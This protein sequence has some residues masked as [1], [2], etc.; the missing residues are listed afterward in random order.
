M[1]SGPSAVE[2]VHPWMRGLTRLGFLARG[3]LYSLIGLLT[4]WSI[5]HDG[6]GAHGGLKTTFNSI[7][8]LGPGVILLSG[9]AVG[10]AGFALGMMWISVF[11]LN[12]HGR[13]KLGLTR[14]IVAFI[15]GLVHLGLV[16]S[17]VLLIAG[18]QSEG[19]GTRRWTELALS[20]HFGREGVAI[21]GLYAIGFGIFL[22]WQVWSG[23]LDPL[24][25]L[26]SLD[27]IAARAYN[28]TGRFGL[29]SRAV[30]YIT[31]GIVLVLA[32]V[33]GDASQVVGLG[34]AM[35]TVGEHAYGV[36]SLAVMASGLFAYGC[37][38]F[39]EARYRRLGENQ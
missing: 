16:A 6:A 23:K 5:A 11:D 3:V 37:F 12:S 7:H 35:K 24:L 30:I 9:L 25:D 32:A 26:S 19:H 17:C 27:P 10:F 36:A 34:G 20:Y 13:G 21:A 29:F 39:I 8:S 1:T 18:H 14:R 38:M 4:L 22:L 15:S 31:M 33:R 28:W 2:S